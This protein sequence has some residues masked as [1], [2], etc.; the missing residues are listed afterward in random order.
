MGDRAEAAGDVSR[1]GARRKPP[2]LAKRGG[3]HYSTLAVSLVAAIAQDTGEVHIVDTQNSGSL[4][5]L[6]DEVAVELPSVIDAQ[7][8]P[9]AAGR[10]PY[11]VRGLVQHV[12]A[13]EELSIEAA[14]TG[15]ERYA[16][17]ALNANPLVPSFDTAK[18][19]WQDI[20]RENDE[21]LP[22]S[23][24]VKPPWLRCRGR[25]YSYP[26]HSRV[27]EVGTSFPGVR[28]FDLPMLLPILNAVSVETGSW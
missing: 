23:G 11:S 18:A 13:Y 9:L 4:G 5:D 27:V 10:L 28:M 21:M 25:I 24:T 26:V 20:R 2:L 8:D 19:L 12:K 16:L 17:L 15:E 1:S 6:P 3:A 14:I 22:S 7:G